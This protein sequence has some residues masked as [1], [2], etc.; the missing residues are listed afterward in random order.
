MRK[1][2][3]IPAAIEGSE[4]SIVGQDIKPH[5]TPKQLGEPGEIIFQLT[6]YQRGESA[7]LEEN[8]PKRSRFRV[9][10]FLDKDSKISGRHLWG[11][12]SNPL[13][14]DDIKVGGRGRTSSHSG[15][16][17]TIS[18]TCF[19]EIIKGWRGSSLL[20]HPKDTLLK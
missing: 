15:Q 13:G 17:T 8:S 14:I 7:I 2:N 6:V 9:Y 11:F 20:T 19:M 16:S 4:L 12:S 5:G 10:S 3:Q 1:A 18:G